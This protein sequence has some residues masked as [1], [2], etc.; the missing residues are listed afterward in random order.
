MKRTLL[1]LAFLFPAFPAG[2]A[3]VGLTVDA[4]AAPTP[5]SPL[6]YGANQDVGVTLPFYRQ[7]GNRLTGYNWENNASSAGMDWYNSSDWFM[8]A[9]EGIPQDGNQQPATVLTKFHLDN[10]ALG[11]ESVVTLQ[12]GGYVAADGTFGTV[13]VPEPNPTYW[14]A[15]VDDKGSPLSLVPDKT[16]NQVYM[17]EEMNYLIHTL[18]DSSHNGIKYYLLDNEPDIWSG[19]HPLIHPSPVG[20]AELAARSVTLANTITRM[21]PGAQV[22]GPVSYGWSGYVNL[23]GASDAASFNNPYNNNANGVG[24]LNYYL[25]QMQAA[26]N[27]AGH[28]LLHYLDLHWYSEVYASNGVSQVRITGSDNN[29]AMAIARMQAPRSLWDPTY[30]E[31]SWVASNLPNYPGPVTLIPRLQDAVNTYYP[32]TKLSFTE[33]NYGGEGDVSGGIA[34]AD[35][36]GI[37][38]KYG[39]AACQ[40]QTNA[41]ATYLTAAYSLY[42]NYDGA[43]SKFGDLSLPATSSS[44][45]LVSTYASRSDSSPNKLWVVAL[46]RDYSNVNTA[47]V[48]VQNLAGGQVLSSIRAFRFGVTS[49]A[50]TLV[51]PAPS[52][53]VTTFSDSL[54]A[55]S[56]TVY[57]I[58]LAQPFTTFTPTAT[59]TPTA[60]PTPTSTKTP[61]ATRTPTAT[62]TLATAS[63]TP[64]ASPTFTR[65][66]TPSPSPTPAPGCP[67]LFNDCESPAENGAWSGTGATR[68]VTALHATLG[69]NSLRVNITANPGGWYD[70]IANLSGFNPN[71]WS[72]VTDVVL[73]IYADAS[74]STGSTYHQLALFADTSGKSYQSLVSALP[75]VNSGSNTVTLHLNFGAGSILP[76]DT[77]TTLYFIYNSDTTVGTGNFYIDDIR[78]VRSPCP[79]GSA[80]PT[81]SRTL[82]PTPTSTPSATVSPTGT[83]PPSPTWTSTGTPTPTWSATPTPTASNTSTSTF[84]SSPTGT[85]TLTPVPSAT[86]TPSFTATPTRTPSPTPTPSWTRTPSP[87]STWTPSDT[88]SPT[89]TPS[90]TSTASHTPTATGTP[91]PTPSGTWF[92]PTDTPIPGADWTGVLYP[93]PIRDGQGAALDLSLTSPTDGVAVKVVTPASRV[94]LRKGFG[95]L[96]AGLSRLALDGRD[97][98]GKLFANG[99]YFL[100]VQSPGR[101]NLVLKLLVAR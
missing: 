93:N 6:T 83:L 87:T 77:L 5:I 72:D 97:L 35:A 59:A 17:D 4:G 84:T 40:W 36:L 51:T 52:F 29:Q 11:A 24:F 32:G 23:Q 78:L 27:T 100:V 45:S 34:H 81:A 62:G 16:D 60:S 79:G 53:A 44:V 95:S 2:A 55:R 47:A 65:S 75:S 82:T 99:V 8:L 21:D 63:F 14:K 26:S 90:P 101:K 37:F 10:R 25:A 94:I 9:A 19:T 67:V 76:A 31:G 50:L 74:L 20:Y 69:T 61:T 91:S 41:P 58:T 30:I 54:P 1:I 98:K 88:P 71:A 80:T 89:G 12:M 64:S 22:F 73:D 43:G 46:N 70:Q 28:R 7:G 3:S 42:L 48:T 56:G 66:A 49:A 68:A 33:W 96:P 86:W 15:V 57:E 38:G 18:G 13:T 85:N 92:Y 39:V